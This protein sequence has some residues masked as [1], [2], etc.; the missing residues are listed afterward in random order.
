[1]STAPPGKQ[2]PRQGS[3]SSLVHRRRGR[4]VLSRQR[5]GV[6]SVGADST[7]ARRR[8]T[9]AR[10]RRREYVGLLGWRRGQL[11]V[12]TGL[13]RKVRSA[14]NG[15]ERRDGAAAGRQSD[16][17]RRTERGHVLWRGSAAARVRAWCV[18]ARGARPVRAA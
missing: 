13:P 6:T 9:P 16:L 18:L 15:G 17:R 8:T 5:R 3:V 2:N 12:V 7:P 4:C 11:A 10:G 14:L 1:M